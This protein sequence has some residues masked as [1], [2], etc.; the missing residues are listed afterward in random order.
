[1]TFKYVDSP[2]IQEWIEE[3]G[4]VLVDAELC[5]QFHDFLLTLPWLPTRIDWRGLAYATIDYMAVTDEEVVRIAES[6]PIGKHSLWS[7]IER[8]RCEGYRKPWGSSI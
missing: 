4:A 2:H 5:N 8:Q 3:K 7:E 1:V 6:Y